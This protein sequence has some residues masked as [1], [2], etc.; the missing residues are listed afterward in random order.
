ME[1]STHSRLELGAGHSNPC[2]RHR[3]LFHVPLDRI[4]LRSQ[5]A[6]TPRCLQ[7]RCGLCPQ[8]SRLRLGHVWRLVS[9]HCFGLR[10]HTRLNSITYRILDDASPCQRPHRICS[11][12]VPSWPSEAYTACGDD[13]C[14]DLFH[15]GDSHLCNSAGGSDL[16]GTDICVNC[17]GMQSPSRCHVY[18]NLL[19]SDLMYRIC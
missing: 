11:H 14:L 13:Y 16:L 17:G 1:P 8:C 5:S 6:P 15:D 4:S 10:E 18:Q 7:R 3:D 19:R 12:G 2:C 9:L